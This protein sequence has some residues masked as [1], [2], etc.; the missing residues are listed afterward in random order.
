MRAAALVIALAA[1]AMPA[2]AQEKAPSAPAKP[3]APAAKD[4]SDH[5]GNIPFIV[6][7]AAGLKEVEFTGKPIM[8]FYTA[9]W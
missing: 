5:M 2:A 9:T 8:Y 1:F 4:W 7:R 6:G 3:A